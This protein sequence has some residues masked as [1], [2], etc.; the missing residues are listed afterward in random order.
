MAGESQKPLLGSKRNLNIE[1]IRII[2]MLMIITLHGMFKGGLLTSL[3]NPTPNNIAAWIME[4]A[5]I[6][7]LNLFMLI[8]GY[9]L[10]KSSFK[11]GR[12]FEIIAQVL[13]YSVGILLVLMACGKRYSSY[14][15]LRCLFPIQNNVYW[16][17]TSYVFLYMLSP[18]LVAGMRKM[19]KKQLEI[20]IIGLFIFECVFK[21][22]LPIRLTEDKMGYSTLWFL[23][24]FLIAGYIRLYGL[25][26]LKKPL[27]SYLIHL[28]CVTLMFAEQFILVT[29]N[30][31]TGRFEELIGVSIEH[32]HILL[33]LSSVS[34]FMA[35]LNAPQIKGIWAKLVGFMAPLSFGVY[36]FHEHGLIRY[37]WP[38]WIGLDKLMDKNVFVFVAGVLGS[39]ILV[40]LLGGA[41]DYIRGLLFSL[42]KKVFKN[43]AIVTFMKKIDAGVNSVPEQKSLN[44]NNSEV[45]RNEKE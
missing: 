9:L 27:R 24:M 2:S 36:L 29:V 4:C 3:A 25:E 13:F 38:K 28:C 12:L 34:L 20:T 22:V 23:I 10:V 1:L 40:Y 37:E 15:M 19:T 39:A 14:E 16:F 44:G 17:C 21:T 5:N 11:I 18:V 35:I 33:L 43:S 41:V 26:F 6:T 31:R 7:G 30:A 42:A 45:A 8:T 32:N